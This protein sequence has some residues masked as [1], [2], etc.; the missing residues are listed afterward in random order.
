MSSAVLELARSSQEEIENIEKAIAKALAKKADKPKDSLLYDHAISKLLTQAQA[1]SKDAL[2][3]YA[4][5]DNARKEE[6]AILAGLQS[7]IP[8]RPADVWTNFYDRVRDIKEYHRR[9]AGQLPESHDPDWHLNSVLERHDI[10]PFFSGE[11]GTGRYLDLHDLYMK[12][13]N[14]KR[15]REALEDR[16][17]I[18]RNS[19][20]L[21][22]RYFDYT[23]YLKSLDRLH[24]VP[25]QLKDK[26]YKAYVTELFNYLKGFV[27]RSDPLVDLQKMLTQTDAEFEQKWGS[28]D[29]PG[30]TSSELQ[31]SN[32]EDQMEL[33]KDPLYCVPCKKLFT[34]DSVFQGHL[35]GKKHQKAVQELQKS[36]FAAPGASMTT[37]TNGDSR[38][39]EEKKDDKELARLENQIRRLRET[40]GD[41]IQAT[42]NQIEKKQSRTATEWEASL[43]EAEAAEE[44]IEIE[45]ES[46]D[47]DEDKP[48]YNPKNLPLGWDGKPIPYWLYKLHGLGIEYK[49]EICGDYSYWGRRAFERHFQEWRHAYGMRRLRIPNTMHFKEITGIQD[50]VALYEKLKVET[51]IAQ[52]KAD[53]EQEYEDSEGNVMNKKTFEDLRRQGLL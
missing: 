5:E 14:L 23:T 51:D 40:L 47:E 48:I 53:N 11:E 4:D 31:T 26:A 8:G 2:D 35:P 20:A 42:M 41:V 6:L 39:E 37:T 49:C 25:R 36:S 21:G 19:R 52:F 10:M 30:W 17:K 7:T 15:V 43:E 3:I 50:A 32:N 45:E 18:K 28:D 38:T 12:F 24:D 27:E 29:V 1:R 9:F 22:E 16:L 46:E 33:R 13:T 44:D 34:K